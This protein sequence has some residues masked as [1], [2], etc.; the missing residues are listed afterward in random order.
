MPE[1]DEDQTKTTKQTRD[2]FDYASVILSS[3]T[4]VVIVIYT[5]IAALQWEQ[6]RKATRATKIAADAAKKVA[7]T[8]DEQMHVSARPYVTIGKPDGPIA[9]WIENNQVRTGI[10]VHFQNAG[11]TPAKQLIVNGSV[12][13]KPTNA[14]SYSHLTWG[15]LWGW[16]NPVP[17]ITVPAQRTESEQIYNLDEAEITRGFRGPEFRVSG[18]YEYSNVFGEY[19]CEIFCLIWESEHFQRCTPKLTEPICPAIPDHPNGL[20]TRRGRLAATPAP[21]AKRSPPFDSQACHVLCRID[22]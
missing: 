14:A 10:K 7:N 11:N 2:C 16:S 5:T 22:V 12:E 18:E 1:A 20:Q 3:L 21:A 17:S 9:E 6:M 8:A 19:C 15:P 13:P 4:L